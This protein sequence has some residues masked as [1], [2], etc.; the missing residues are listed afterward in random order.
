MK[1]LSP[2]EKLQLREDLIVAKMSVLIKW[3]YSDEE[4]AKVLGLPMTEIN[5]YVKKHKLRESE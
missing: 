2:K 5:I 4:I 3:N 1:K